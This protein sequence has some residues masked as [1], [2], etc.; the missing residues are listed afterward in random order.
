M[1]ST[2]ACSTLT[3]PADGPAGPDETSS[4][5]LAAVEP[6]TILAVADATDCRGADADVAAV[7]DANPDAT[8]IMV[9]DTAYPNGSAEDFEN[10]FGPLYDDDVDR[11]HAVPGD[12]DYNTGTAEPFF[13]RLGDAAGAPDEGWLSFETG[14]WLVVGLNS[15]CDQIGGCGPDS[16]QYQW[17]AETLAASPTDCLLAFMHEPRFTSSLNYSGIPRLGAFYQLLFENGADV[18]LVG[19]SHH[20]ERFDR[21]NP[22]GQ[23]DAAGIANFTIGIGGAPFTGFGEPLPGSAIR[24]SDTRG[25]LELVLSPDGYTWKVVPTEDSTG[26][27]V[28]AGADT[29]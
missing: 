8:L 1:L 10:C 7:V 19:H 26:T 14:G 13:E 15:N 23:P 17:L 28:D 6:A 2:G 20:Y 5:T 18:L 29:C 16:P 9:G 4:V 3:D 21:L 27:L 22:D 12:N 11:L 25:V 24:S